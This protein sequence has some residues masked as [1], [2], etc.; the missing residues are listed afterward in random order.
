MQNNGNG[1]ICPILQH[2]TSFTV[3]LAGLGT[4]EKRHDLLFFVCRT[5]QAQQLLLLLLRKLPL[6][7]MW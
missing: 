2:K 5:E 7:S 6:V 3:H 4:K 1:I